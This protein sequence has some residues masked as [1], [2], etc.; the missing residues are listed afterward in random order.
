MSEFQPGQTV[1][2]F[3]GHNNK[4]FTSGEILKVRRNWI[5]LRASIYARPVRFRTNPDKPLCG[6]RIITGGL[7]EYLNEYIKI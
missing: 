4:P 5:E 3:S 2:I 1:E 7:A 6:Y